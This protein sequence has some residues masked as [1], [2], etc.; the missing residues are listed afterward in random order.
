MTSLGPRA[1]AALRRAIEA[2]VIAGRHHK[3]VPLDLHMAHA[4]DVIET[5][6][7]IDQA[8]AD[9]AALAAELARGGG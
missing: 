2:A 5:S 1:R 3:T 6:M 7:I 8:E 4:L 9:A